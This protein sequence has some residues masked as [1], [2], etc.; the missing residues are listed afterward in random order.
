MASHRRRQGVIAR[1]L[2]RQQQAIPA[3]RRP[4]IELVD[5]STKVAH[6]VSSEALLAGRRAGRYVALCGA[7]LL[8]ASLTAP[9]CEQCRRC[10]DA[11]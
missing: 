8:S 6:R 3:Q 7:E 4:G 1:A 9:A 2:H 11:R 5:G 10:A